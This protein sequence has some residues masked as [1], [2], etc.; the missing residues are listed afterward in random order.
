[1][2]SDYLKGLVS[3]NNNKNSFNFDYWLFNFIF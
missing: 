2:E 3:K 1:M